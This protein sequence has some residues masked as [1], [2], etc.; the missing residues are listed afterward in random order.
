MWRL[1]LGIFLSLLPRRWRG[2]LRL[3][4]VIPWT[5]ATVLSGLLECLLALLALVHWYLQSVP[6]WAANSLDSA[7]RGGPERALPGQAIGF[8][9]L[10]VWVL[11][12]RTWYIGYFAI[13]GVVRTM[14]AASVGQILGTLPLALVDWCIRKLTGWQPA[15]DAV[16]TPS[17]REQLQSIFSMM[18]EKILVSRLPEIADQL[19]EAPCGGES[20]LEIHSSRPKNGW[21]PPRIV[22][23][24]DAYYRLEQASTGKPPWPFV[25]R[26]K[27]LTAGVPGRTVIVYQAPQV[28]QN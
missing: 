16:R 24:E 18:R 10:V 20:Y 7:L 5:R 1:A 11:H 15:G 21:L 4:G 12:P 23:I 9:A 3:D 19:V 13:E 26:L 2:A 14:G 6:A 17:G 27:R 25:F 28:P 8:A 22:R